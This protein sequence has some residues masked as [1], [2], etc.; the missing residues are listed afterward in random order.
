MG[1]TRTTKREEK[2]ETETPIFISYERISIEE[3]VETFEGIGV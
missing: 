2:K 3:F 1:N